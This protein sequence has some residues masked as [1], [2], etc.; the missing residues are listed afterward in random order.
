MYTRMLAPPK[1]SF[2]LFGPRGTGKS[3]WLEARF[4][5]AQRFD[6]LKNEI[7]LRYLGEPQKW[8]REV[9]G[10]EKGTWVV[11]DEVQKV[12]ALLD[13]VQAVMHDRGDEIKFCLT[14]SSS[15][16]LKSSNANMLAGR[17]L[18][19]A[20]FS[21]VSRELGPT[22]E[23]EQALR[24]GTLPLV[25]ARPDS[26]IGT[27]EAYVGTYLKEEIQQEALT[28]SLESF[29]RF[30]KVAALMNAQVVNVAGI[31]RDAG[32]PR[33]SV[34]RYFSVL[35]DTLIGYWV[36]GWQPRLKVREKQNPKFYFFDCG[37]VRAILGLLRDKIETAER[38][39][40]F[41]TFV[42]N[43]VRA[44]IHYLDVGGE[45]FYYRTPAGVEVDLIWSRGKHAWGA[46]IKAATEWKSEFGKGLKDLIEQKKIQAAYGIYR[47]T[48]SFSESG[49]VILPFEE[50]S[51][52]L[53][54]GD[55]FP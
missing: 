20:F 39:A 12:P 17:A 30:L 14:G 8:R 21:L 51:K 40:L 35:E 15:R 10:L 19:K 47:G 34:A 16:K 27:L 48:R 28:R 53:F 33:P 4:A 6:F 11:L 23:L 44:A 52:R 2:F 18:Q 37:V 9:E 3:T 1:H 50:F 41:E 5:E 22:F 49:V 32:V 42:F 36:P 45:I 46:E 26:A 31:A 7:L 54:D 38:G 55:L 25:C 13:E 43:E 29:T 24:F